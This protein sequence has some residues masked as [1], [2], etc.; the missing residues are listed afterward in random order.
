MEIGKR[1]KELRVENGLKQKELAKAVHIAANTLSQF[2]AGK[3]NPSY[4][5]LVALADYFEVSTD[6]LLGRS[7]DFGNVTVQAERTRAFPS[8]E[9]QTLLSAYRKTSN[10]GKMRILAYA[11]AI[12]DLEK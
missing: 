10:A 5:V 6:Y 7:D 1:I 12:R 11:E 3:S 2:E 8:A 9:E 4:D